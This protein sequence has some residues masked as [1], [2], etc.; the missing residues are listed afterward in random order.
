M[1]RSSSPSSRSRLARRRTAA[2]ALLGGILAAGPACAQQTLVVGPGGT[3]QAIAPAIA[4]ASP[5]DTV[6]V[7]QGVY[8]EVLDIDKGIRLVGRGALLSRPIFALMPLVVHDLPAG[9]T[10]TMTG[11]AADG[12][13]STTIDMQVDVRDCDGQVVLRNLTQNGLR[14]WIV[15]AQDAR[16]LHVGDCVLR[17]ARVIDS[18]AVFASCAFDPSTFHGLTI[19][20]GRTAVVACAVR[21]GNGILSGAGIRLDGGELA[22]TRS[23]VIGTAGASHSPAIDTS[24]GLILL[25]PSA[26]L[27]PTG[28]E[29]A[30]RGPALTETFEFGS[31][32]G[33]SDG[34]LLTLSAHGPAGAPFATVLSLPGPQVGTA[35]GWAWVDPTDVLLVGGAVFPAGRLHTSTVPH[36]PLPAGFTV[37]M[38]IAYLGPRGL[39]LGTPV[40]VAMP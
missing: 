24:G 19:Q 28:T 4:A 37:A 27:S 23:Q 31:L 29:P 7:Q 25:D 17:S 22:V 18:N 16:L 6:L 26:V 5:G 21:G 9:Q 10:F 30:V 2:A 32:D 12:S 8:M 3:F 33:F 13:T 34:Q 20:N 38:Q 15:R 11:F 35:F 39:T 40:L 14:Q 1:N 36:V